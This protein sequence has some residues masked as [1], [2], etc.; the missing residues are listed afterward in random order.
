MEATGSTSAEGGH[1]AVQDL[2][3]NQYRAI[4]M[5]DAHLFLNYVQNHVVMTAEIKETYK[6]D[7]ALKLLTDRDNKIPAELASQ[8]EAMLAKY[9]GE[10]WGGIPADPDAPAATIPATA[11]AALALPPATTA[12]NTP[13]VAQ[14][15]PAA[16]F[17]PTVQP[18]PAPLNNT[19][20]FAANG[21]MYGIIRDTSSGRK[22]Y[23]MRDDI[24][25]VPGNV[26]GHNGIPLG[27]WYPLQICALFWGAHGSRIGGI[28][29]TGSS[30]AFSIVVSNSYHELDNDRGNT[31][32][33]SGSNSHKNTNPNQTAPASIGT[34]ALHASFRNRQPVRVLR[35]GNATRRAAGNPHLPSCGIRYDGLYRVVQVRERTNMVGGLYEQF[36]LDRLPNQTPLAQLEAIS[37]TRAQ[38]RSYEAHIG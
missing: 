6:L 9:E 37:P 4:R 13:V 27:Q 29:G 26:H 18:N 12:S 1:V 20:P 34:Q 31:L 24:A 16:P 36:R 32:Y 22:V 23:R 30:G 10:Q 28:A 7:V 15:L 33:Y 25:R 35:A 38:R 5:G 8:A 19:D 17:N 11:Q 21:I 14:T 2:E 3:T